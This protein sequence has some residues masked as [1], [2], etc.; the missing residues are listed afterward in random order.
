MIGSTVKTYTSIYKSTHNQLKLIENIKCYSLSC[1][2]TNEHRF[3]I[4]PSYQIGYENSL[5]YVD[6]DFST[7]AKKLSAQ[8][9]NG[10]IYVRKLSDKWVVEDGASDDYKYHPNQYQTEI[11]DPPDSTVRVPN[12]TQQFFNYKERDTSHADFANWNISGKT[13]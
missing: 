8:Q 2:Q 10:Y 3:F 5:G 1:P 7:P 13:K 4:V 6:W 9:Q 11:I 12:V